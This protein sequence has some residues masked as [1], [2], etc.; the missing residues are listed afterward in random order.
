MGFAT[1]SGKGITVTPA[2]GSILAGGK[3]LP[4]LTLA[5]VTTNTPSWYR[6]AA[7]IV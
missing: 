5:P 2:S 1:D 7:S 6:T 4:A 3:V